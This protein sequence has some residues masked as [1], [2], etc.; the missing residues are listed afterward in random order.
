MRNSESKV[1]LIELRI[2]FAND[3][4]VIAIG[5]VGRLYIGHLYRPIA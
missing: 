4:D 5:S 1:P 3:G 2:K